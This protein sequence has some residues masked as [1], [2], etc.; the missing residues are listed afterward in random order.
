MWVARNIRGH[1]TF[2][3]AE[4]LSD[5]GAG[6]RHD[7]G[8]PCSPRPA[9]RPHPPATSTSDALDPVSHCA[10]QVVQV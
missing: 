3:S 9:G 4:N 6:P 5:N 7:P 1:E 2:A 10:P 8:H